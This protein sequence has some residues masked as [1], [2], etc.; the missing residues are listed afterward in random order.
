[1]IKNLESEVNPYK[2][3]FIFDK[4]TQTIYNENY[5]QFNAVSNE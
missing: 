4:K 3:L 1:L 5:K 2:N